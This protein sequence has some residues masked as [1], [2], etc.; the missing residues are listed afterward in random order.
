M[1]V[2]SSIPRDARRIPNWGRKLGN[3]FEERA[4]VVGFVRPKAVAG[5]FS[6]QSAARSV[7]LYV[8][9]NWF[10]HDVLRVARKTN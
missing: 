10:P 6:G 7:I 3:D 8:L 2:S 1:I 4:S 9:R 5:F